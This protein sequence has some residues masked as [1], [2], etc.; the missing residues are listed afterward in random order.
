MLGF[1]G[2]VF[3]KKI[4]ARSDRFFKIFK[5][6]FYT[7][8]SIVIILLPLGMV[9]L[10]KPYE[11]HCETKLD[12]TDAVPKWCL[13]EIPNVYNYIQKVYWDVKF[14]GFLHRKAEFFFVALPMNIFLFYII[15]RF[16]KA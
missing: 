12:R 5:Y 11:M 6:V 9:L 16:A 15:Y 1:T 2:I 13:D 14:M 10:W 8:T 4:V 7:F 3:L